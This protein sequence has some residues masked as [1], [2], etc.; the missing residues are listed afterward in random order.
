MRGAARTG[1]R[2][3][4]S[5]VLLL[6][7]VADRIGGAFVHQWL[8]DRHSA[9]IARLTELAAFA[10]EAPLGRELPDILSRAAR[11]RAGSGVRAA[12]VA[13]GVED[14]EVVAARGLPRG[15]RRRWRRLAPRGADRGALRARRAGRVS[16]RS[17][18]GRGAELLGEGGFHGCLLLPLKL[19]GLM[20]GVLYLADTEVR[21]FSVEEIAVAGV[22][23]AMAA[24]AIENSR[25]HAVSRPGSRRPPAQD[26]ARR[27]GRDRARPRRDGERGSPA[28]SIRSSRS[29]WARAS[30]CSPAPPTRPSA[31]GS[32]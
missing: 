10:G 20:L 28:S 1:R 8:L 2:S 16:R 7:V 19:R 25:V 21:D 17:E 26:R 15:P 12:A 4:P 14:L 18:A 11:W 23:A 6:L 9:S 32:V 22:L 5:D 31:K 3:A 27:G 24:S 30:S 29:S 13:V